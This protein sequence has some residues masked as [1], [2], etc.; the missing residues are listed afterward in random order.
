MEPQ[1]EL[2]PGILPADSMVMVMT[3][4][5]LLE[6]KMMLLGNRNI[7]ATEKGAYLKGMLDSTGLDSARFTAS[8]EYYAGKPEL[9]TEI[10][11]KVITEISRR[12]AAVK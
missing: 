12:Q 2:P 4:L 11:E 9:F 5:H 10:Y 6:S 3:E 7:S 1:E 8:F